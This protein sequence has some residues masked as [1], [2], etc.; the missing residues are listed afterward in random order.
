RWRVTA[1]LAKI[2]PSRFVRR[3]WTMAWEGRL[4]GMTEQEAG[5]NFAP[6]LSIA[7]KFLHKPERAVADASAF[8]VRN[9][10]PKGAPTA[11]TE[12]GVAMLSSEQINIP[13]ISPTFSMS[14]LLRRKMADTV[15]G[16]RC[17]AKMRRTKSSTSLWEQSFT[18]CG[19]RIRARLA[20]AE[21]GVTAMN[22]LRPFLVGI[23][24]MAERLNRKRFDCPM[25]DHS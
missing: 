20:L 14:L 10:C 7:S 8:D 12:G 9:L 18:N 6:C 19:L 23:L 3:R 1:P 22:Q 5:G 17:M 4:L 13:T 25:S 24:S 2:I 15:A 21:G 16:K 11:A